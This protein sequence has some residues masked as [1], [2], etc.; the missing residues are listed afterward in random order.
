M[1]PSLL[2]YTL[3]LKKYDCFK[4]IIRW[5][6]EWLS[7]NVY[8]IYFNTLTYDKWC[9][10]YGNYSIPPVTWKQIIWILKI[11]FG[12]IK[13]HDYISKWNDDEHECMLSFTRNVVVLYVSSILTQNIS[14]KFVKRQFEL[15]QLD[16]Y[17]STS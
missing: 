16:V 6:G 15:S 9:N 2:V 4:S 10:Y 11:Y 14:L 17:V 7:L 13:Q 8:N 12:N 5:G 1:N 3:F